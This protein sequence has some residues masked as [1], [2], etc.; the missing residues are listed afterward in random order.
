M[1]VIFMGTPQFAVPALNAII[2]HGREV[3]AVYTRAPQ[4]AGRRGLALTPSP[5]QSTAE[6]FGI[7]V[8][9]PKT[10][11]NEEQAEIFRAHRADVAVVVAYGLILPLSILASPVHGCLNLHASLLPRWR[12][13]APIQRAIMAGDEET[14]IMVMR[15]DEGLDTGPVSLAERTAIEPDEI[16]GEVHD[17]LSQLGADLIIRALGALARDSLVFHPQA[18]NGVTYAHRISKEECRIDWSHPAEAVHNRIRGLSPFPGAFF[19]ADFGRGSE[20]IK[21]L[22]ASLAEGSGAPG[23][24]LDDQLTIACGTGAVR[25]LNV[26]RAGKAPMDARAFLRGARLTRD[27]LRN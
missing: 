14:G 23:T 19:D 13:A 27:A 18:E 26:Q 10:L 22:R 12:G 17:R 24:L 15:M 4:P 3:V 7:A 2:G 11:R 21:V 25:L 8:F 9:T 6:R 5:I 1:R 20:R 16:A